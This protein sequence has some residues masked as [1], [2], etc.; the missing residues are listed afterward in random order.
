M[1]TRIDADNFYPNNRTNKLPESSDRIESTRIE[2]PNDD[3]YPNNNRINY[4]NNGSNT[5]EIFGKNFGN[6]FG[7][8][9]GNDIEFGQNSGS[10]NIFGHNSGK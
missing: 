9:S 3:I 4:P 6:I 7:Q 1:K 10:K 5:N 8:D 2:R